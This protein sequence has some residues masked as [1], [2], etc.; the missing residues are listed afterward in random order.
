MVWGCAVCGVECSTSSGV[1][2]GLL[3]SVGVYGHKFPICVC[4]CVCACARVRVALR[5][6]YF[7][8]RGKKILMNVKECREDKPIWRVSLFIRWLVLTLEVVTLFVVHTTGM[9]HLRFNSK[10][11]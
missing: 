9:I 8:R 3:F 4:V 10:S 1:F 7:H 2:S 11:D 6:W 5:I